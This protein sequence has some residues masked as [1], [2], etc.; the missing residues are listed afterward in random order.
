MRAR[1][2]DGLFDIVRLR[3]RARRRISQQPILVMAGLDPA[4]HLLCENLL[5]EE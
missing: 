5:A 3:V 1:E 2:R 4:I